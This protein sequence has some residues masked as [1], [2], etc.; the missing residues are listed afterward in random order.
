M[1]INRRKVLSLIGTG[2]AVT[3]VSGLR[4]LGAS[5]PLP[6][7]KPPASGAQDKI[8][9]T[10]LPY[11]KIDPVAVAERAYENYY[12]GECMYAVFASVLEE[13]ADKGGEPFRSYPTT[14]ARFGAGGVMGW[15]S[16]CGSA[17]GAAMAV[18]LLSPEPEPAIDEIM[19]YYGQAS[20]PD[21]RPVQAKYEVPQSVSESVLCHVS[22]SRWCEASGKKSFS[23]ERSDRCGQLS[24]SVAKRTVEILNAQL[25]GTFVA[26]HPLPAA[27]AE[28][29]GCHEKGGRMENTRG[30]DTCTSCHAGFAD[31]HP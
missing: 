26:A 19:A 13:L 1:Y 9:H 7:V 30:K 2:A 4:G 22:V 31:Q 14:V 18:Y 20:L 21:Y 6:G 8:Q 29:R 23:P 24:A 17:N 11:F 15:G 12:R 25:D 5:T 27:V 10:P 3:A 16:L 28:C